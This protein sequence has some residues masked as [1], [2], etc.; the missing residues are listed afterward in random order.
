MNSIDH[1]RQAHRK[2][3]FYDFRLAEMIRQFR[4][5]RIRHGIVLRQCVGKSEY[6]SIFVVKTFLTFPIA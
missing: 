6:G 1:A 3:Q 4:I 5:H 2:R